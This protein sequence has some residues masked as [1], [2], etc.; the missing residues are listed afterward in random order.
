ML[1]Q[2]LKGL[3]NMRPAYK[4]PTAQWSLQLVLRKVKSPSFEPLASTSLQLLTFKT[5]F[6]LAVTS[7]RR[8]S[9]LTA[10]WADPPFIQ[11]H[12]DK[13]TIFPDVSFLLKVA[14]SFHLNQPVVL[15]MF[16]PNLMT[17]VEKALHSLDVKRALPTTF[18]ARHPFVPL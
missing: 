12:P 18:P 8:A 4:S 9:E 5:A 1:K 17:N 15:P 3:R 14:T 2:F 7:V 6:L 13:V 11:F 10:L 16:F